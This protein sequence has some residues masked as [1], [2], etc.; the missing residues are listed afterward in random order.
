MRKAIIIGG[1]SGIGRELARIMVG[2]GYTV[3]VCGRRPELLQELQKEFP[4]V[5]LTKQLDVVQPQAMEQ[6]KELITEMGGT[7]V[8]VISAGTG[9]LNKDLD[10]KIEKD[11]IDVNVTGFAAMSNVAFEYFR[12]KG[13]GHIV[14]ISSIA[15]I[16]GGGAAPAYNASKAFVSNY[17]EGLRQKA[18]KLHLAITVTDIM[19]GLVDTA[20]A[21]GAGL[22]WV[23]P[24]EKAANQIFEAIGKGKSHA[25]V[26]KR[27]RL[28]AWLLKS[29]PDNLYKR[30]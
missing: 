20:M 4:G 11:T 27:W 12:G 13:L 3:G 9:D 28:I 23:A 29:L 19:P 6:L 26:T 22:F 30:L 16:R 25:Y 18:A 5:I 17:L 14:G 10:W 24:P 15:A 21:K 7:D 2:E 8:I 1:T